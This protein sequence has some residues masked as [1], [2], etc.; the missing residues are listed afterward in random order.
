[1]KTAF[2]YWQEKMGLKDEEVF[3]DVDC[4]LTTREAAQMIREAGLDFA[5]PA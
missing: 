5:N 2:H 3:N 4:V 1:M